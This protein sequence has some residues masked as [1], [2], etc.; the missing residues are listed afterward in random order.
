MRVKPSAPKV[1]SVEDD[2]TALKVEFTDFFDPLERKTYDLNIRKKSPRGAWRRWCITA[3]NPN[4]S[5][6]TLPVVPE[7]TDLTPD[8]VY[9]VQYRHRNTPIC[10]QFIE[11]NPGLRS[12][13]GDR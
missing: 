1:R 7:I 13:I 9:E 4:I 10:G 2:N 3:T 5:S 12:D 11:G 6:L 8:T